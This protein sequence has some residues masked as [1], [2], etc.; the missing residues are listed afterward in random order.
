M[1]TSNKSTCFFSYHGSHL[2]ESLSY[3]VICTGTK[4]LKK[5]LSEEYFNIH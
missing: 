3:I 1:N 2:E 4:F 5:T